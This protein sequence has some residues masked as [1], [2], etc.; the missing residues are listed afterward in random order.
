M[1]KSLQDIESF[2][3]QKSNGYSEQLEV[4]KNRIRK[5][6]ILRI[7]I[8]LI[9][10]LGIYISSAYHWSLVVGTSVVGFGIFI[11]LVIKHT[12]LFKHKQWL[13]ALVNINQSELK[14]L[15]GDT[16]GKADGA[17]YLN[18]EHSFA[19]D[20]DIFGR[21]SLFQLINRSA[22]K[23]GQELLANIL[24]KPIKD[25]IELVGRQK[26][27]ADLKDK[28]DWRQQFQAT[29]LVTEDEEDSIE[30]VIKWSDSSQSSF[31]T[32][33]YRIML[34][35][36]PLI[37]FAVILL[38]SL[39]ILSFGA[40]VLFLFLPFAIIAPKL[41]IINHEH[42][43]LSR[44][45]AML[46]KYSSLMHLIENEDF[47][48]QL[49]KNAKT[50][51]VSSDD[52]AAVAIKQ[53]SK[54]SNTFDFRLNFLVGILLNVFFL[55][56]IIQM[57]RLE[58]WKNTFRGKLPDWFT[59]LAH[60]DELNSFSGFAFSHPKSVFPDISDKEFEYNA[61]NVRHPFINPEKSVGNDV[62][63][64]GWGTFLI[65]TGANMAGKSTYLRTTGI[66]LI[67]A[68]TGAPVLADEFVFTPVDVYTGIKTSDSLQDGESYFFAELKRLET[69]IRLLENGEQ[70]FI[71]LDEI[72][73]GT[74]SA[75]KQKGSNALI[76]QLINLDASGMIAT[77]DLS[78]GKLAESFPENVTNKRFEVE[79]KNNELDF[80]YKLK[81]GVSRNLN[82]T[83]LMKKMGI[84]VD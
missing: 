38:I 41:G 36:N 9:T 59:T 60:I 54:I 43:Q 11:Y 45:S 31:N 81:D 25:K 42:G 32:W 83:F 57:I 61:K 79:I 28:T 69:I 80:D 68:M 56:D 78:L 2:F 20:L 22:T 66:N 44:K 72:L 6:S 18:P 23:Q 7:S 73:R 46:E 71:L 82:A 84:T 19:A 27:V 4:T 76:R 14:L 52:S 39:N 16:S 3:Q 55:W 58:K 5:T 64:D 26:A 70:L 29:G 65:T 15:K 51:L 30:E 34:V 1:S 21:K 33:F 53:L 67:L 49:L 62:A 40:F 17:E 48:S 50:K 8:F 75:D 47:K 37:G 12:K 77:H 74:N 63:V 13:T 10:V 35:L 24:L